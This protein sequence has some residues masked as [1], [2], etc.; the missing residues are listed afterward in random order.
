MK[1]GLFGLN[2]AQLFGVDPTAM[3]CGL[4]Q[5]PLTA[6]ISEAAALRDGGRAALGLAAARPDHAA[7]GAGLARLVRHEVGAV[8]A[9]RPAAVD[10]GAPRLTLARSADP[11]SS[12][13]TMR[14]WA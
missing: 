4:T 8:L 14:P 13:P 1:A 5:D 6:N 7:P 12:S 10:S 9:S 3:R 2:A 11:F